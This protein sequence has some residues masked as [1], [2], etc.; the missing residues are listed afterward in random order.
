MGMGREG[1]WGCWCEAEGAQAGWQVVPLGAGMGEHRQGGV[2]YPAVRSGAG[3]AQAR[4]SGVLHGAAMS[5][6]I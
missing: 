6:W 4:W 3:G 1:T 5:L 2:G